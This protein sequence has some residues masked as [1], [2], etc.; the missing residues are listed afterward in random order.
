[1]DHKLIDII[2]AKR[3]AEGAI[4]IFDRS[5]DA[6]GRQQRPQFQ[7]TTSAS[8][9]TWSTRRNSGWAYSTT[10]RSSSRR[11]NCDA[12]AACRGLAGL[13]SGMGRADD[14]V[15][16]ARSRAS[17]HIA[18]PAGAGGCV[19]GRGRH[20]G[21]GSR[22]A[23][24]R[25]TA[26]AARELPH[27]PGFGNA[28]AVAR[29]RTAGGFCARPRSRFYY[30][31]T[32]EQAALAAAEAFCYGANA[33]GQ[34]RRRRAQAARPQC[35]SF[36]GASTPATLPPVADFGFIDDGSATAGEVM[37]LMVRRQ[38]AVPVWCPRPT[39]T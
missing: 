39:R 35:W 4:S 16:V 32:G 7:R 13:C 37:N 31:V 5:P 24:A 15:R 23:K 36:C 26:G 2:E 8:R 27:G 19:E 34:D 29:F 21:G 25:E 33:H 38:S 6:S 11:W 9:A 28:R 3:K 10:R 18:V 20:L 1:M 12:A 17:R 22:P 30:E 14:R